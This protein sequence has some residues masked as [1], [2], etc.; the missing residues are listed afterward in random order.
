MSLFTQIQKYLPAVDSSITKQNIETIGNHFVLQMT[1][2]K[3]QRPLPA[4]T[5][6]TPSTPI[7]QNFSVIIKLLD[8]EIS[9]HNQTAEVEM[10]FNPWDADEFIS[11]HILE[12]FITAYEINLAGLIAYYGASTGGVPAGYPT[13]PIPQPIAIPAPVVPPLVKLALQT[14]FQGVI[15]SKFALTDPKASMTPQLIAF[16]DGWIDF[17]LLEVFV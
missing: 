16:M 14:Y 13:L 17:M 3:L 9:V 4:P 1:A 7:G 12:T 11:K 10:K 2:L 8:A 5:V 15:A 6:V